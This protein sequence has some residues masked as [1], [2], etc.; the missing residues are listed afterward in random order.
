MWKFVDFVQDPWKDNMSQI[1]MF[2]MQVFS[3][4]LYTKKIWSLTIWVKLYFPWYN[5]FSKSLNTKNYEFYVELCIR[6]FKRHYL[7][8]LEG[9]YGSKHNNKPYVFL[10]RH[11]FLKGQCGSTHTVPDSSF[12]KY[13]WNR[14]KT[15]WKLIKNCWEDNVDQTVLSFQDWWKFCER[16]TWIEPHCLLWFFAV[17][18]FRKSGK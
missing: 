1:V 14:Y 4:H 6:S 2:Q 18:G 7:R 8:S 12:S 5:F 15:R 10:K 16:T 9:Q 13:I 17:P 11:K 3:K